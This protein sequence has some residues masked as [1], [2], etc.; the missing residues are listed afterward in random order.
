MELEHIIPDMKD[1]AE[2]QNAKEWNNNQ[3]EVDHLKRKQ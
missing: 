1:Q 3:G 2:K